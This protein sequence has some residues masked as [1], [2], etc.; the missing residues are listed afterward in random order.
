MDEASCYGISGECGLVRYRAWH[1]LFAT[2]VSYCDVG[3]VCCA[4]GVTYGVGVACFDMGV[5][6]IWVWLCRMGLI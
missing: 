6:V 3:V 4:V 1:G 2:G 5:A